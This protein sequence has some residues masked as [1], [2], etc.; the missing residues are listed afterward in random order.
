MADTSIEWTDKSWNPTRG[1]DIY[2]QECKNCYAMR[3]AHRFSGK[4]GKYEGLTKLTKAGPVWTGEVRIVKE[5]LGAPLQWAA[6][7]RVFVDSMSDLFYGDDA[8]HLRAFQRGVTCVPVPDDY[9]VACYEI[10]QAC[11]QHT[12]QVLT[13]RAGRMLAVLARCNLTPLPNVLMGCSAG[14]QSAAD[15]RLEAM[16]GVAGMGWRTWVSYE[17]AIGPVNWA[18]WEFIKWL[19][20]GEESGYGRRLGMLAWPRAAHAWCAA[21]GIAFFM[22]Q[23]IERGQKLEFRAF[24]VDLQVREYPVVSHG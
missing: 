11:P 6:P 1:C 4:G 13:K 23:I 24:P 8:D 21:N 19:V 14:S 16:R 3:F 17:P 5:Q 10:M 22:K 15:E 12:F 2:S 7:A 9:I 18:G 20:A